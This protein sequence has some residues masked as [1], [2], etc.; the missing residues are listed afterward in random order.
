MTEGDE[1][2][3]F[4][5]ATSNGSFS[6]SQTYRLSARKK[7][8]AEKILSDLSDRLS[9]DDELDICVLL[10]LLNTKIK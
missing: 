4:E 6:H 3:N 5:L 9:G 10:K 1:A 8:R 2:F 7:E